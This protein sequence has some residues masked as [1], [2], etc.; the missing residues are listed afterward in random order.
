MTSLIH[1]YSTLC[2]LNHHRGSSHK[3]NSPSCYLGDAKVRTLT[4]LRYGAS[5]SRQ[6]V[7]SHQHIWVAVAKVGSKSSIMFCSVHIVLLLQNQLGYRTG[8]AR[9]RVRLLGCAG[10]WW[11]N[12]GWFGLRR[13]AYLPKDTDTTLDTKPNRWCDTEPESEATEDHLLVDS[14]PDTEWHHS[15]H[16]T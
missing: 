12:S 5:L 16:S 7:L 14:R 9:V 11:R 6:G 1:T 10:N 8:V 4:S 13:E 2:W 15:C 3:R